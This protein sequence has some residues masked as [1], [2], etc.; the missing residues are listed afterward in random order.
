MTIELHIG[1]VKTQIKYLNDLNIID[2]I[3]KA[4]TYRL[5]AA[6][7]SWQ[8]K[9]GNW[10][11]ST[12]LLTK[13]LYF[14]SGCLDTVIGV[15]LGK[16]AAHKIID[17]RTFSKFSPQIGEWKGYDLYDYQKDIVN[18]ALDK[19]S[20]MIKAATGCHSKGTK[21][22]MYNG[23]LKNVEDVKIGDLLM[24]PD[25]KPRKVQKLYSGIDDMFTIFPKKGG[26]PFDVN[27]K[28]ILNLTN[29]SESRFNIKSKNHLNK[30][31]YKNITV[32]NYLQTSNN[33]KYLWKLHRSKEITWPQIQEKLPIDPWTLGLFLGNINVSNTAQLI[34]INQ[35]IEKLNLRYNKYI[36][37]IYKFSSK[38]VRLDL[39]AGLL[40]SNGYLSMSAYKFHVE[41]KI[42]AKDCLFLSRSLGLISSLNTKIINGTN[43]YQITISGDINTIPSKF[44][45]KRNISKLQEKSSNVT[46]FDIRYKGKEKFF[47]FQLDSDHLYLLEDFTITHNSGKSLMIARMVYEFNLPT[48]IYVV[49]LDLLEQMRNTLEESLGIPIGMVGDGICD[50]KNI[51]VCSAWTAGKVYA[52]GKNKEQ[53]EEDVIE[54]KW[55]PD[56]NQYSD[57]KAM[58]EEAKLIMLD[59]AQFAAASSIRSILNNSKSA[60]YRFGLSGTPWRSGGDDLLLEAAFG[61]NI[62]DLKA[63]QLINEGYLVPPKIAFRDILPPLHKIPRKWADVKN[64]Y[65]INN[66]MRNEL[67]IKNVVKLL[68]MG[69][70]PLVL[71]RERKHGRLLESLLPNNIN[72]RYVTGEVSKTERDE[73]RDDFKKGSV[74][75]ILASTVYDQGIDLPALDALVLAGGGKSTAK[76]LQ[77]IGRVIRGNPNGGKKDALVVETYDQSHYVKKHSIMRYKI[78][79]TE[80]GFYIKTG[81]AMTKYVKRYKP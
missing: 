69:R 20:G 55:N 71:F 25:S 38:K 34:T 39:L 41:S 75:L 33:F 44:F 49:S 48:V 16:N 12:R 19:K 78:Y 46:G 1:N 51:T 8:Y 27:S 57:I 14:P 23:K 22:I 76:A 4:L 28:H 15:L 26:L 5:D 64:K 37:D 66:E 17:N 45:R 21:V 70:K 79:K 13:H 47:G 52:K 73:I 42:L 65:I 80:P 81:I 24:G 11:G 7:F 40:D 68:D 72:Y 50:I 30:I 6:K 35:E 59:E 62:C 60:A 53:K 18:L 77:R 61:S 9:T 29:Q 58:I 32:E 54:D 31:Q 56:F 10:D 3:S 36:P 63:T 67:L 2:A 43:Y 74:D